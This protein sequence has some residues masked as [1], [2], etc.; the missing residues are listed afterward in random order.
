[1]SVSTSL[2]PGHSC[3]VLLQ[4]VCLGM[5]GSMVYMRMENYNSGL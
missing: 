1:M 3:T 4:N 5:L 2:V